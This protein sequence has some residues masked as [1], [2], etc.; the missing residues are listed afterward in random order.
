MKKILYLCALT[1]LL[2]GCSAPS[3]RPDQISTPPLHFAVPQIEPIILTNGIRVYFK[4]DHELPLLQLTVL[5]PG[6]AIDDPA[7]KTG[8]ASL[9]AR[10]MRTAGTASRSADQV[11]T[12]LEQL[13]ADLSVSADTYALTLDLSLM[14]SDLARGLDLL[15]EMLRAP[16]FEPERIELARKQMLEA[17]RRQ[18]DHP[19]AI[20][21]RE[22]LKAVYGEHPLGRTPTEA[23]VQA[24]SREDLLAAYQVTFS[25]EKLWIA[26]SGDFDRPQLVAGLEARFASWPAEE[27]K[28]RLLPPLVAGSDGVALIAQ[29]E[30]PQSVV[31]LGQIGVDKDAPDLH[32]VRVM[33]FILGGG[34]FNS[35]MMKEI[36]EERGLAYSVYSSFQVGRLLPGPFIAQ[37]ETKSSTT[38]EALELMLAAMKTIREEQVRPEELQI[39]KE[40]LNNSFVFSFADPHEVVTQSMRLDFYDY[41]AGYL[42]N[43]RAKIE[44]LTLADIQQAARDHL[45]LER[46]SIVLVGN[47]QEFEAP[48]SRLGVPLQRLTV[49]VKRAQ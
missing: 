32:A 49:P 4:E 40:S 47:E 12:D 28:S 9:L 11:D 44:A 23:T 3:F 31:M 13:A 36:R 37:C 33:N 45:Q 1:V 27:R 15:Q 8:L 48:L 7:E 25:P 20:A 30:L 41:P 42:E 17:I 21:N 10:G 29:K 43:Y 35:R 14:A 6:G 39:A 24:I 26:V 19:Q 38:I 22:L 2:V 34:G 18:N 46:M 5:A 16:A